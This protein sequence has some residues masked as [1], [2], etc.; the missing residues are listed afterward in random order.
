MQEEALLDE[1]RPLLRDGR[2]A[3]RDALALAARL[4]IKPIEIGRLCDRHQI[5]IVN[6]QLGCFGVRRKRED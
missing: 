4:Q 3:C 2:L 5:R 6:C 1:I